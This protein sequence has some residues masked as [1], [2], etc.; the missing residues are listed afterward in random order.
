[1]PENTAQQR[2]RVAAE[3]SGKREPAKPNLKPS[4]GEQRKPTAKPAKLAKQSSQQSKP[5]HQPNR[6][7][8]KTKRLVVTEA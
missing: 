7:T 3:D 6:A 4:F 2:P 5:K 1:M 8:A